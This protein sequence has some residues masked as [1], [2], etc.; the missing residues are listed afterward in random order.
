MFQSYLKIAWRNIWKNTAF[1]ITNL[2]GLTIGMTCTTLILLWVQDERSWDKFHTNHENIYRLVV[3]RHF[4]GEITTDVAS[5]Y[6]AAEALKTNFPEIKN[7]TVDDYGGDHVLK[8]NE[9]I[10]KKRGYNTNANFLNMLHW[11]FLKGNAAT[12]FSNPENI[13]ITESTARSLFSSEEPVGKVVKFDNQSLKTVSAVI[14]D[15]PSNSSFQFN[16]LTSFNPSGDFEKQASTDWVNSFTETIVEVKQ[17]TNL[18]ELNKKITAFMNSKTTGSTKFDFFLHPMDKWRLYSDF[19][20]G[21]NTGGLISY[22]KLF[23]II[24]IIIL[25][26]ACVNFMNL[27]TA[28]SERRAKEVGIRKTVGSERRPLVGEF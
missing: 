6:P 11:K 19:K 28:Q 15:P 7:A 8:Y 23:T 5:P 20:N 25:V 21:V 16:F 10:I 9:T 12:A 3:N 26:I 17:G 22:V 27:S 14:Q 1:S 18:P 13:V 2:L 4:N 24:A